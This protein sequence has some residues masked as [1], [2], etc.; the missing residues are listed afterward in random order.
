MQ[1]LARPV[2][3]PA[4]AEHDLAASVPGIAVWTPARAVL[5][6]ARRDEKLTGPELDI[7][8]WY[9]DGELSAEDREELVGYRSGR[10]QVNLP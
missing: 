7:A 6:A 10:C 2:G 8:V 9:P 1:V 5:D 4:Y 3:L